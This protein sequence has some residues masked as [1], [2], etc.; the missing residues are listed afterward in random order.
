VYRATDQFGQ[1][2][3]VFVSRRRDVAAARRLFQQAI[4]ATK[5]HTRG[6]LTDKAATYPIV[7]KALL[8]A[9]WHRTE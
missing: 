9:V 6:G 8:P 7:L 3:D 1:V 2:V 4:D 5:G